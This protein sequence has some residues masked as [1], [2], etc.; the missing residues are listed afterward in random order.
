MGDAAVR[1]AGEAAG[2]AVSALVQRAAVLQALLE[3]TT[4]TLR[5]MTEERDR[6]ATA[7]EATSEHRGG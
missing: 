4:E 5:S 3:Q 7:L 1:A 6:L 2:E